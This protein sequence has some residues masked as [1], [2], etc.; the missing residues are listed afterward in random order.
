MAQKYIPKA[1]RQKVAEQAKYRC[2]YCLTQEVVSG[3][4]MEYDHLFPQSFGGATVEENLWLACTF[5][6]DAKNK[7]LVVL[8]PESGELVNLFNPRQQMWSEHFAWI[9]EGLFI[10]GLTSVGRA[11]VTA[12]SLNRDIILNARKLWIKWDVHPPT[13]S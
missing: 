10:V 5:C 6:N 1:L 3:F 7:R 8:D 13:D 2:G 4:K 9:E 11:T 12:L